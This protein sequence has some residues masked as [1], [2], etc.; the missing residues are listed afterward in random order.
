MT[1]SKAANLTALEYYLN[2]LSKKDLS[3]EE[4]KE[5]FKICQITYMV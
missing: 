2:L 5:V 4:L 1:L 3:D